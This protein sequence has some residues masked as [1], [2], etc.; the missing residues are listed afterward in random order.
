M[1]LLRSRNEGD[2]L[3]LGIDLD[4]CRERDFDSD[5]D[6]EDL[7]PDLEPDLEDRLDLELSVE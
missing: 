5:L 3:R 6:S 4:L 7:E 1:I 2:P